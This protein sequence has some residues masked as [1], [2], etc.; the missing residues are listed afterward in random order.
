M[1]ERE[2]VTYCQSCKSQSIHTCSECGVRICLSCGTT[3]DIITTWKLKKGTES[4][5]DIMNNDEIGTFLWNS[6]RWFL[7]DEEP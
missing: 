7:R 4:E 3:H 2:Q 6:G 1:S 5:E